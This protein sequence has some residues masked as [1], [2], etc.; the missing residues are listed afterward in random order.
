MSIVSFTQSDTPHNS[1]IF[2]EDLTTDGCIVL[3]STAV[4]ADIFHV[5][6]H[7]TAHTASEQTTERR[8]LQQRIG[9]IVGL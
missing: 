7:I 9:N 4:G 5:E 6:A 1:V 2:I 8:F 3:L